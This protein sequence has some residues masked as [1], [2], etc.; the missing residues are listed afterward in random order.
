MPQKYMTTTA[1]DKSLPL[2]L[3]IISINYYDYD[4]VLI[5]MYF[6]IKIITK[7]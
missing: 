4:Y 1:N 2:Y 3:P 7:Y 5:L 6:D